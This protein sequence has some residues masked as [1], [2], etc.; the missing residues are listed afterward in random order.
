MDK[1]K[2]ILFTVCI[3]IVMFCHSGE[4]LRCYTCEQSPVVCR[5]NVTCTHEEDVCLQIRFLHLRT[6]SCWKSSRCIRKEVA[7]EFNADSFRFLCCYKD[8]CNK[9]PSLLAASAA[10]FSISA[11]IVLWMVSQ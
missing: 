9:S 10:A 4:A 8:L 6:Y 1:T 7:D 3:A 11:V 2:F 5:T